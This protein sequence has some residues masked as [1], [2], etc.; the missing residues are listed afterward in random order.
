MD[1]EGFV[2]GLEVMEVGGWVVVG[3]SFVVDTDS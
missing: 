1:V 3:R 2:A